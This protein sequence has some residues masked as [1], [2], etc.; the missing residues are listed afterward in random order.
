MPPAPA[1]TA[2]P[3]EAVQRGPDLTAAAEAA[4]L[5][6]L[7]HAAGVAAFS[8]PFPVTWTSLRKGHTSGGAE[9]EGR[10]TAI[11]S[12]DQPKQLRGS[13]VRPG[14]VVVEAGFASALGIH[15]GDQLTLGDADIRCRG[16]G[17]HCGHPVLSGCVR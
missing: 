4:A 7:E 8:G 17:G 13:W 12:V 2:K 16:D 1:T 3:G 11:S 5:V 15:V 14:G 10:S 6:P 9:V